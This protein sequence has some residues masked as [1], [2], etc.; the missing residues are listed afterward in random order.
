MPP[1]VEVTLAASEQICRRICATH[2]PTTTEPAN[3]Q[4]SGRANHRRGL[5]SGTG[6]G[7]LREYDDLAVGVAGFA[8][9]L[10][11]GCVG[12]GEGVGDADL[13]IAVRGGL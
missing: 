7:G 10:G 2:Q 3:A 5:M 13:Q 4:L 9:F 12:E 6:P 1:T 11:F 8:E